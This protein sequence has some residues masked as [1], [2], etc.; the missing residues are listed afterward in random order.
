LTGGSDALAPQS[1][2][3]V[4]ENVEAALRRAESDDVALVRLEA[5]RLLVKLGFEP[6]T[7]AELEALRTGG[8][9][10]VSNAIE[11]LTDPQIADRRATPLLAEKLRQAPLDRKRGYAQALGRLRDPRAV[12]AMAEYLTS[13]GVFQ[14]GSWLQDFMARQ[15]SNLGKPGLDALAAAYRS[16][17]NPAGR[18]FLAEGMTSSRE[19]EARVFLREIAE[20]D[21]EHPEVRAVAI[22]NLPIL[23]GDGAAPF[24]KRLLGRERDLGVRRL[25]NALLFEYY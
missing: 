24:L 13:P 6:S 25:V 21:A 3:S 11:I 2:P 18:R 19:T 10:A 8:P 14:D 23:E 12:P 16:V 20:N 9:A 1:R 4:P 7:S 5:M 22:R 17:Q 15:V